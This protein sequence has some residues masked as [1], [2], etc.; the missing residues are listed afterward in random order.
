[1]EEL[2][3]AFGSLQAETTGNFP[4]QKKSAVGKIAFH[5]NFL[6]IQIHC[7]VFYSLFTTPIA[8]ILRDLMLV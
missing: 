6:K 2:K 3:M 1:M 7:V 4:Y 5:T 8:H